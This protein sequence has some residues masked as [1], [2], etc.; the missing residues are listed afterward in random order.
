M[1]A[2]YRAG[3]QAEALELYRETRETL[4][5]ELGLEPGPAL[6]GLE[7]AIL[8]QDMSLARPARPPQPAPPAA[9]APLAIAEA[10]KTVTVLFADVTD[11]TGLAD[12]LDPEVLRNVLG[13]YFDVGSQAI[14]RH[15]GFVEKF[16][17]DALMA[18]FGVPELHEDDAL[19]AVRA[20][21]ELRR[22]VAELDAQL[23][24]ELGVRLR[25][26]VG[27]NT[28]E[29]VVGDP[30]D[31][32]ALVSGE[33]V[34]TAARLEQVAAPGDVLLGEAT[35]RLVANAVQVESLPAREVKGKR[36]SRGRVEAR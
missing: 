8:R 6:R 16:V 17:G 14:T 18:V 4:L 23:E 9:A 3:R 31:G 2:F 34:I 33:S 30:A 7:Q 26:R 13:R 25:V 36:G 32:H 35:V 10:R 1:R 22:N 29:V 12:R 15:G 28:G 24:R 19:R 5:G 20:A 27:V 21:D 11:S